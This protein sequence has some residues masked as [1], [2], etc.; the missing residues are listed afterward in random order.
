MRRTEQNA[1]ALV[2]LCAVFGASA[3]VTCGNGIQEEGKQCE[4]GNLYLND[5]CGFL[6]RPARKFHAINDDDIVDCLNENGGINGCCDELRGLV[7]AGTSSGPNGPFTETMKRSSTSSSTAQI[8][9][10]KYVMFP[11]GVLPQ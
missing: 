6:R 11:T 10:R 1:L 5:G 3:A 9:Y 4:D 2:F 7:Q 8:M